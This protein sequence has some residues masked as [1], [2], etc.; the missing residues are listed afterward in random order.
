[1]PVLFWLQGVLWASTPCPVLS[2]LTAQRLSNMASVSHLG[3]LEGMCAGTCVP[4][5]RGWDPGMETKLPWE[6]IQH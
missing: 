6:R 5:R 3:C 2:I 4:Q 1:M